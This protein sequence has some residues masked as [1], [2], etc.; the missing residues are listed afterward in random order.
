MGQLRPTPKPH[1]HFLSFNIKNYNLFVPETAEIH[2][3]VLTVLYPEVAVSPGAPASS[4]P[5]P[6]SARCSATDD[7]EITATPSVHVSEHK[8]RS[9]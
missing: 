5:P 8:K 7:N 1:I 9:L 3:C 2:T 6:P 4:F